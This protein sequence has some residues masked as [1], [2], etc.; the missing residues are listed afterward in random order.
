MK[1]RFEDDMIFH[2]SKKS[3]ADGIVV[4]GVRTELADSGHLAE[5]AGYLYG[6]Y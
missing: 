5:V 1:A 4:S 3:Q 2:Q 6:R